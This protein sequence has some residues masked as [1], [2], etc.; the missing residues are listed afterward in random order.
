MEKVAFIIVPSFSKSK[1]LN[2]KLLEV[3]QAFVNVANIENAQVY[4]VQTYEDI[5]HYKNKAEF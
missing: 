1:W 3:T 4:D 5:K 2:N